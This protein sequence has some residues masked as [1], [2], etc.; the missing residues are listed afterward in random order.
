MIFTVTYTCLCLVYVLRRPEP[1]FVQLNEK[2]QGE[3]T[4]LSLSDICLLF[5]MTYIIG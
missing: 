4:D 1:E 5:K 2:A 3:K